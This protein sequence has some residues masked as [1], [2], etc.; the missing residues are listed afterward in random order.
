MRI[1]HTLFGGAVTGLVIASGVALCMSSAYADTERFCLASSNGVA[2]SESIVDSQ[3]IKVTSS[4]VTSSATANGE[5]STSLIGELKPAIAKA[6]CKGKS[7]VTCNGYGTATA[8]ADMC[9]YPYRHIRGTLLKASSVATASGTSYVWQAVSGKG[10]AN[11]FG[12]GTTYHIGYGLSTCTATI[13]GKAVHIIGGASNVTATAVA[14]GTVIHSVS[15]YGL[16]NANANSTVDTTVTKA[17]V[18]YVT[19]NGIGYSLA[20]ASLVHINIYQSQTG[21]CK[22]TGSAT[23]ILTVGLNSYAVGTC[24]GTAD[25]DLVVTAVGTLTGESSSIATG[26]CTYYANAKSVGIATAIG[27]DAAIVLSTK[28]YGA[29]A[30]ATCTASTT[31]SIRTQ[32]TESSVICKAISRNGAYTTTILA[33]NTSIGP[34]AVAVN[35]SITLLSLGKK[36]EC[37]AN[38]Y[39]NPYKIKTGKGDC[40]FTAVVG[41]YPQINDIN[42]APIYRTIEVMYAGNVINVPEEIRL[43]KV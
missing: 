10:T 17:G 23:C 28:S 36:A 33:G 6:T 37:T 35:T 41:G 9:G 13:Y 3:I 7:L 14:D 8:N 2:R 20:N 4:T 5:A 1:G 24:T 21:Y 11:S 40:I 18:K 25:G 26:Y 43:I 15:A 39:G 31:G 38:L 30:N 32:R 16:A 27:S 29:I 12:F 19:T 22:A 42:R 34:N